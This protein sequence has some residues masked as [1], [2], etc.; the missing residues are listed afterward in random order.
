MQFPYLA[1][2]SATGPIKL[3]AYVERERV[4]VMADDAWERHGPS[5]DR[6]VNLASPPRITPE[7]KQWHA[8]MTEKFREK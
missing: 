8:R 3:D 2:K 7:Y 1:P 5:V 6:Y 4:N